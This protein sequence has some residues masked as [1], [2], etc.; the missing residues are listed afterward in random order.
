MPLPCESKI[1]HQSNT[2]SGVAAAR[3]RHSPDVDWRNESNSSTT[4]LSLRG[5]VCTANCNRKPW[6]DGLQV[7][8]P[9]S[10]TVVPASHAE[11]VLP[12]M[13]ASR[14]TKSRK[15]DRRYPF[16]TC[17]L[18]KYAPHKV[19]GPGG[20]TRRPR[21]VLHQNR[22]MKR[23]DRGATTMEKLVMYRASGTGNAF[24]KCTVLSRPLKISTLGPPGDVE[25]M[26][27]GLLH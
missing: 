9:R 18:R 24:A 3:R 13:S 27:H 10:V 7:S 11:L 4:M 5:P 6:L 15:T 25:R 14:R 22:K 26:N 8:R 19:S 20:S 12:D 21:I 2:P 17:M 23:R 1:Q 16:Y